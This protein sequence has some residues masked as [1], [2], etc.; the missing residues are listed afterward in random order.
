MR[1]PDIEAKADAKSK[2]RIDSGIAEVE[3]ISETS[4]DDDIAVTSQVRSNKSQLTRL[5]KTIAS[6]FKNDYLR[7]KQKPQGSGTKASLQNSN[8]GYKGD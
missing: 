7:S 6:T 3:E 4:Q 1:F 5:S 8:N 2:N